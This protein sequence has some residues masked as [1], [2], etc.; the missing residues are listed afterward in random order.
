MKSNKFKTAS[1]FVAELK[2]DPVFMNRKRGFEE[3]RAEQVE[4]NRLI[5]LPILEELREAGFDFE[6]LH[7]L[8]HSGVSYTMAIPILLKWLPLITNE[9]V[10]G[11][12]VSLLGVRGAKP[13]AVIPLINEFL[14]ISDSHSG[15]KWAIGNALG[16]ISD[17]R[18]F[19]TISE[20]VQNPGHGRSRQML[21]LAFGKMKN[22][23]A[24]EILIGLLDD[25]DVSGHA[26]TA[27]A[28]LKSDRALPHLQRFAEDPRTWVRRVAKKAVALSYHKGGVKGS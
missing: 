7:E 3:K 13:A 1:E 23:K 10:K 17:D 5:A 14:K 8:Q 18:V 26:V 25:E 11:A 19:D 12:I 20:L 15:L 6:S 28:K 24:V 2:S 27:L 22:P 21:V 9:N 16:S 4:Q